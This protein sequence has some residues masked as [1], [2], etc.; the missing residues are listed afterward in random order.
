ME[1]KTL[2]EYLLHTPKLLQTLNLTGNLL[3]RI[4]DALKH[5]VGLK[6]LSLDE[7]PLR[8]LIDTK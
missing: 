1:L 3:E 7:N 6:Y 5:A 8:N 2:P 4:P